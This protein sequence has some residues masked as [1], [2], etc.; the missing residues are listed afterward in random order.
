LGGLRW[1]GAVLLASSS[2]SIAPAVAPDIVLAGGSPPACRCDNVATRYRDYGEWS[3]TLLDTIYKVPRG[4]V[5]PD[6]VSTAEAGL[7]AGHL[8]RQIAVPDLKAV[9]AAARDA[10]AALK[11]VS[12]YRSYTSQAALYRREVKRHGSDLTQAMVAREGHSEHQLGVAIDFGSARGGDSTAY[13]ANWQD[14]KAGKWMAANSWRYGWI[15]GFPDDAMSVT[16]YGYEPWHFRYVGPTAA[17]EIHASGLT[18]RE[19][20]WLKYY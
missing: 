9:A 2:L 16:C 20:L 13:G 4:Y 1:A 14:S 18:L 5:P 7:N 11:V 19:W 12:S 3:M 17:A 6:L 15:M 8:I 10:G